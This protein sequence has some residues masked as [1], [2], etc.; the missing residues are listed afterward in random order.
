MEAPLV[1]DAS[2]L[3]TSF[4]QKPPRLVRWGFH[5]SPAQNL[6]IGLTPEGAICRISFANPQSLTGRTAKA[7][8]AA[9]KKQWPQT[10]FVEDQLATAKV[11][12]KIFGKEMLDIVMIG[13]K[14]QQDVWKQL[15]KIPAGK[16]L[17]YR[18]VAAKIK[19]P[20]AVR[21]VGTACG[22]NP[23]ALL[24]PCHR[25]IASNGGMGGFGGGLPLKVKLLATEKAA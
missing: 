25:V 16:T 24:V 15:L 18:E 5:P 23:V 2:K 20:K 13:T 19:N 6:M 7:T 12:K 10:E 9:W 4:Q 11:A 17:S 14:F 21:A 3:R 22:A 1:L 8:L